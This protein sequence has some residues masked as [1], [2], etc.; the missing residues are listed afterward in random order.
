MLAALVV[1]GVVG[2][3]GVEAGGELRLERGDVFG[4]RIPIDVERLDLR[5]EE[6]VGAG[7]AELGETRGVVR[8]HEAEDLL[9]VLHGADEALLLTH[10]A[11][12]PRED[13][14]ERGVALGLGE[15]LVFRA[16]EGRGVA[17]LGRVFRLDEGGG[18]FDEVERSR[19]AGLRVVVPRDE[20]VLAHHDRLHAGLLARDFLHGEAELEAGAHPADIGHVAAE[21]FARELLA[22]AARG[23]GDDRVR[24]H[25]ID[26]LAGQEAVE[27]R[28]DGGRARV[29]V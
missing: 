23:D 18:F 19:V 1:G 14:R 2:A 25:V 9:V 28:V 21:D 4:L 12:E 5:A 24:V 22:T 11:A 29:E 13:G 26:V 16:A 7:G 17:A 27:R 20:A 3:V 15:R 8:I 10:L 6:V